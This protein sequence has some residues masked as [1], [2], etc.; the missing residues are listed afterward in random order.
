LHFIATQLVSLIV[1]HLEHL[2]RCSV[3]IFFTSKFSYLHFLQ[4][5]KL[6]LEQQIAGVTTTNHYDRPIRNTEQQSDHIYYTLLCRCTEL[7]CLSPSNCTVQDHI[8]S[9]AGDVLSLLPSINVTYIPHYISWR[10][11]YCE[12][13]CWVKR[14]NV[15]SISILDA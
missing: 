12:F 14:Q 13:A 6:K 11:L 5:I 15:K 9:T 10:N 3:K 2:Q 8:R 1:T 7:L 4:P